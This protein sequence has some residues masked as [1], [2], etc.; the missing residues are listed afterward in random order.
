MWEAKVFAV[1][2]EVGVGETN[3]KKINTPDRADLL[4]EPSRAKMNCKIHLNYIMQNLFA[5]L[6]A[7]NVR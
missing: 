7:F 1:V 3:W 5:L 2:A 4:T 6:P